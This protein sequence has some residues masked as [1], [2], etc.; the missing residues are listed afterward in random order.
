MAS[1]ATLQ[2]YSSEGPAGLVNGS[3]V[4]DGQ[5]GFQGCLSQGLARPRTRFVE[6]PQHLSISSQRAETNRMESKVMVCSQTIAQRTR[7]T[8]HEEWRRV[9]SSSLKS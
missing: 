9:E 8:Y 6:E 4:D 3:R 1:C 7:T 5:G 2:G